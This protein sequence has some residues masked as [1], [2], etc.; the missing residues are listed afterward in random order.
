MSVTTNVLIIQPPLV[1]LNTPYPAG[2]YLKAF[3]SEVKAQKPQWNLGEIRWVEGCNLLF[4]QIFCKKGLRHVFASSE[5]QALQQA[6]QWEKAGRHNEAFNVRRYLSQQDGWIHWIDSIV[7]I[8]QGCQREL[9]H[10]FV[11][12]P[13]VPR[14]QRMENFLAGLESLPSVDDAVILASLA[15][16]DLADFIGAFFDPSFELVRYGES[17]ATSHK[18]FQAVEEGLASPVLQDF[19]RPIVNQL[20]QEYGVLEENQRLLLCVSCPFPGT[21]A[22]ALFTCKKFKEALGNK[23]FVA[24]GGGYVNTELRQVREPALAS[25]LDALS[26][27]RGYGS[28][29]DFFSQVME[30]DGGDGY[31]PA[32]I[33]NHSIYKMK[34]FGGD[35]F[36]DQG[37]LQKTEVVAVEDDF[38]ARLAPDYSDIDFSQYPRLADSTNSMHRLWSDGA[39]LKAY[40]AHGC[41]W[42]Q[43]AFCDT[44]LDYVCSY[45]KVAVKELYKRL[46]A[47]A[48]DSGVCGVHLVDEAAPPA[49]LRDF[50]LENVKASRPLVFWGNIRY[51]KVFSRDLADVLSHGGLRA[52]S[53]GIEIAC[54][55]G[56]D[57][58][59]K[60]TDLQSIV[61]ACAAFK[62]AGILTHAYMIYGYWQES[63]QMLIDS[64][65]TLRQLFASGLLDSAFW[66]K[67]VLT[68]HSRAFQEWKSGLYPDLQPLGLDEGEDSIFASNDLGFAGEE[69]SAKYGEPLNLALSAWMHGEDL[70]I[71]VTKWFPFAM[72]RP[73]VAP[74]LV[75]QA[76]VNY[77]RQRDVSHRDFDN[78]CKNWKNYCWLGGRPLVVTGKGGLQLTWSYMGEL[79]YGK[80][81]AGT[82]KSLADQVALWL[83]NRS[84]GR[85]REERLVADSASG[86][87]DFSEEVWES[88]QY[89]YKKLRGRGLC[90]AF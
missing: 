25:Y 32:E 48:Q 39:W 89:L 6:D 29:W 58:V 85:W 34:F 57:A 50:A 70:E 24:L 36:V 38:T 51:E 60:G 22:A 81:P 47:Q 65:E 63:P 14:G 90:R 31:F 78:F 76:I 44:S 74:D 4:H 18:G 16:A 33:K 82:K 41:Y 3:F 35:A 5:K 61:S 71:P 79:F 73:S 9:C 23:V 88:L 8:L 87:E 64:M 45:K 13:A 2:A 69:K 37:A 28:Y 46:A 66:H 52:V 49:A 43:C 56:L 54:G 59:K 67:F 83:Y 30:L 77:E 10:E 20:L 21:L 86:R 68:R 27:D 55:T 19:Y 40:L 42:H 1:Q 62:E 15:L 26:Y 75:E 80:F 11:A 72:P 53:G 7:A 84:P 12:S 17:L